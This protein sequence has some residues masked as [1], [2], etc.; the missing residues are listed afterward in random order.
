LHRPPASDE[1]ADGTGLGIECHER[2]FNVGAS[3]AGAGSSTLNG[4]G[5]D[6]NGL[7]CSALGRHVERGIDD[8]IPGRGCG[9][10]QHR[11]DRRA[12]RIERM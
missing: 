3:C 9:V 12:N 4:G 6:S 7:L 1:G 5:L 11:I 10:A 8:E 2:A